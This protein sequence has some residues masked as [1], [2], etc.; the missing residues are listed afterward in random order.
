MRVV[1]AR[2]HIAASWAW[3]ITSTLHKACF[4]NISS[5]Q[6]RVM[7]CAHFV[8]GLGEFLDEHFTSTNLL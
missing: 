4:V 7:T 8:E 1:R 5:V 3:D 2:F 6:Y